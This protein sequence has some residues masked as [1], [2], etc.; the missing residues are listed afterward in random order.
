MKIALTW[1]LAVVYV[2][3]PWTARG[4]DASPCQAIA[5]RDARIVCLAKIRH[6][7][8]ACYAVRDRTLRQQCLADVPD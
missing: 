3:A 7:R 1:L 8:S 4:A 2:M 5:N 6:T